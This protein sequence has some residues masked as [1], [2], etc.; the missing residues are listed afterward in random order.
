MSSKDATACRRN[1]LDENLINQNIKS[2]IMD[3]L[4]SIL[5]INGSH[6][7]FKYNFINE[8]AS[9]LVNNSVSHK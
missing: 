3:G 5:E 1:T 6:L 8:L 4:D 7:S 2:L 9:S